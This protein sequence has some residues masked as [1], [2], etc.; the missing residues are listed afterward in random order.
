MDHLYTSI[1]TAEWLLARKITMIGTFMLNRM[2]IPEELKGTKNRETR[3]TEIFWEK[4]GG[5]ICLTSYVVKT[6]SNRMRNVMT[7]S[8]MPTLPALTKEDERKPAVVKIYDYTKGGTDI[9][10]QRMGNHS[11]KPKTL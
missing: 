10:D 11:A 7:L 5:K 3:S 4:S 9:I 6:K 2:S 1:A 8:A